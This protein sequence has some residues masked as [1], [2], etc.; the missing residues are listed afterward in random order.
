MAY[1]DQGF[2]KEGTKLTAIQRGKKHKIGVVKMPFVHS[3]YYKGWKD[4]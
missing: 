4:F 3:G 1:V 2:A